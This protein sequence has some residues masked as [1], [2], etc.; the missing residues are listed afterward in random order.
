MQQKIVD[1]LA[2][3]EVNKPI[4]GSLKAED[5][6]QSVAEYEVKLNR[7]VEEIKAVA[8]AKE[9][10]N[11]DL[12]VDHRLDPMLEE[13]Q[14]LKSVWTALT[15]IWSQL[16]ELRE[17][18]WSAIQSRK[19]RQRLDGLVNLTKQLP[20]R[21]RQYA[22]FEYVQD[23]L[24]QHL[25]SNTLVADLKSEALRERHWRQMFKILRA[26]SVYSPASMTLSTVWDLDLKKNDKVIKDVILQAQGEMALEEFLK[27]VSAGLFQSYGPPSCHTDGPHSCRSRRPGR[28][29]R[30]TWSIIRTRLGSFAGGRIC[31]SSVA[32]TSTRSRP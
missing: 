9:A 3:W 21:M 28:A 32:R 16:A 5:A 10:L 24:R 23:T 1:I 19:L 4:Q 25:A 11:L 12:V 27:T 20:N 14:D 30:S 15:S 22:A 7:L 6:M 31:S 29:T 18:L 2:S 17:T 26:S 13:L 8:R